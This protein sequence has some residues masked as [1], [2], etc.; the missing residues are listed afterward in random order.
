MQI[1][2]RNLVK[3]IGAIGAGIALGTTSRLSLA[4]GSEPIRIGALNPVTGAGSPYG[5]GMQKMIR[6]A[7]EAVN[8]AGG[9]A[10]RQIAVFAEDS[11]TNPQAAVLAA[12]K[13][14]EVNRVKAIIGTWSSGVTLAVLPLCREAGI[15]IL[16]V[17]GAP[18][19]SDLNVTGGWGYRF[20]TPN[21]RTG[22]CYAEMCKREG[23]KRVATMAFN[24]ASGLGLTEGFA[25]A[26]REMGNELVEKVVYEPDQ[27]SYRSELMKVLAAQPDAIVTGSYYADTTIIMREWVQMGQTTRW[28]IPGHASTP[29][30]IK[31][32]GPQVAEGV[33]TAD[34]VVAKD[35]LAYAPFDEAYQREMGQPGES[36]IYAAMTWDMTI[37]LALAIEAAASDDMAAVSGNMRKVANAPGTKVHNFAEGKEKLAAGAIDYDGASSILDF[38]GNGDITPDFGVYR[39]EAGALVKKYTVR[40]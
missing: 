2:R 22:R 32:V 30:F 34:L 13:L 6:A 11:Q 35:S 14:I 40:V 25:T 12:K 29:E 21:G 26:W 18:A 23:F 7:A 10:G 24:N 37:A 9:V 19:L 33:L 15:P 39:I 3:A 5:T 28:V 4:Q 27:P 38:D 31:A 20:H 17:S 8:A 36:N 16:H 1:D